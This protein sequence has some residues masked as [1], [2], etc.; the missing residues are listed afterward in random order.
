[1]RL[2]QPP[3]NTNLLDRVI[4]YVAPR[5]AARRLVARHQLALAGGYNGARKDKATLSSWRTSA[6]S[7]PGPA[8]AR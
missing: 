5:A 2:K 3:P 1:M 7:P 8:I 4:A 6:G